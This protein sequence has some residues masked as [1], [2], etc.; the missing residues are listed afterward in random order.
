MIKTMLRAAVAALA[1]SLSAPALA[2]HGEGAPAAAQ[3][4]T[5]AEARRAD[6]VS[7]RENFM[8]RDVAYSASARA[9][10]EQRLSA[11][12]AQAAGVSQVYFELELARIVALADNGHTAYFPGPRSRRFNRISQVRFSPMGEDFYVLRA[13][14]QNAD[15]LGARL[16]AIDG[17][18]IAELRETA[19]TL[20]GGI[21]SW[22]DRNAAYFF[23]S[24][25]QMQALGSISGANQASYRFELANGRAATRTFV[26]EPGNPDRVRANSDRWFYPQPMPEEGENW[27]TLLT[28]QQAP[29]SLQQPGTPFRMRDAPDR[30]VR[31]RDASEQQFRHHGHRRVHA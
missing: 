31:D 16:V 6:I 3:S 22:R 28:A 19:R 18:P 23:E 21:P 15:L 25:E 13:D 7:F 4:P 12:E 24:P 11:L 2:Q 10:A 20:S 30:R 8:A 27:R 1:F 26:A 29:W 14:P 17:H 9:E 5:S